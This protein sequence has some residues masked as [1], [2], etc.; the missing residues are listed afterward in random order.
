MHGFHYKCVK[1]KYDSKAKVL[2]TDT[3]RLTYDIETNDAYEDFSAGKNISDF[4]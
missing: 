2:F 3:D 4:S 1:E